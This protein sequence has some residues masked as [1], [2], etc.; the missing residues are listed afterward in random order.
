MLM[1]ARRKDVQDAAALWRQTKIPVVYRPGDSPLQVKLPFADDNRDWLRNGKRTLPVWDSKFSSWRVPRSWFD[2]VIRRA[3]LRHRRVYVIQPFREEERCAPAC[4]NARGFKCTCSCMGEYH[5]SE[6][7][8]AGWFVV[9]E[10]CMVRRGD[11]VLACRLI[12]PSQ[13]GRSNS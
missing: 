8:E 5:G 10:T 13:A 11:R 6:G 1:Q 7:E 4:R 9:S 3:L 2:D 12:E